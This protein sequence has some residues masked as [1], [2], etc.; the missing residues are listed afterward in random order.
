MS[1]IVT[2]TITT[3]DNCRAATAQANPPR[4]LQLALKLIW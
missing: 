1:K 3:D 2:G 4:N